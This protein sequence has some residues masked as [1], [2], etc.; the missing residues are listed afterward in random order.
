[1]K[2]IIILFAVLIPLMCSSQ[3]PLWQG[4]G[5]IVLS[6][7]GNEHDHDDWSAT[8]L[9]LAILASQN[10]QDKLSVYVY[11]NH[12]WGSNRGRPITNGLNSYE[13]MRQSALG[14]QKWFRFGKTNFICGVDNPEAAFDAV[15]K[16]INKSSA[17][18][19]LF[20]IEAG[21]MQVV[22]ES[23]SRA[24]KKKL[25]YVTLITHSEW[26]NNHAGKEEGNWDKHTGWDTRWTFNKIKEQFSSPENGGLT[27]IKILDQN[28]GR[29]YL[30]LKTN[31]NEF[32]WIKT[33]EY[34]EKAPDFQKGSWDWLYSRLQTFID[35]LGGESFD[36]SDAGMI[37]YLLTGIEKTNPDM[38]RKLM[39]KNK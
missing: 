1:M 15:C 35:C 33:S 8:A 23:I 4:K 36:A 18:N 31:R 38:V 16:E 5:R 3:E 7:D 20:I 9:S 37:V 25:K 24:D 10:M 22:G 14:G 32:D 13:N 34:K 29:D 26:N 12:I 21:P 27:C 19:P 17:K 2:K 11:S 39:E 28:G 30:G 6:S